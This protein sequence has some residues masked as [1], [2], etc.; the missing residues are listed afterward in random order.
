MN[1]TRFPV[2]FLSHGGG[3]WPW[4]DGMKEMFARTAREFAQLPSRLPA[5]PKAV[6][7]ITGHWEAPRFSVSTAEHPPMD[8]DYSGF[9]EHTYRLQ[10]P[11]PGSPALAQR[12]QTLLSQAGIPCDGDATRG[13]DHGTFV[14]LS[15]MYPQADVPVVLLSLKSDY[16]AA[17]HIRVGEAIAPLRDEGVLIIGSG[18][19]Y[20]NMSGFGRSGST[21]VAEA[22][23][24]Y[25]QSAVSQPDP[26]VRAQM[27]V[28]WTSAPAARLAH[29]R[30][31]HLLP[32]MVVAGAAGT[33]TGARVFVDHVMEVAMASYQFPPDQSPAASAP[34]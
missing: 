11:A 12:V 17:E 4:V 19:T 30:E 32:L 9:P 33:D 13:F 20:H 8:Y 7:V 5:R 27:L 21:P 14:P 24:A 29:P 34:Q 31:D 6:L 23:E 10:Y 16:D 15:L 26:A 22:F 18:L 1:S 3:P 25:L 2:L 28:Q